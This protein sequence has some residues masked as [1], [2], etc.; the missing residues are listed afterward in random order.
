VTKKPRKVEDWEVSPYQGVGGKKQM[1]RAQSRKRRQVRNKERSV[2]D[3]IAPKEYHGI[4]SF[5]YIAIFIVGL[6]VV[7]SFNGLI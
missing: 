6:I 1:Q 2:W 5:V 4:L 3:N 7:F